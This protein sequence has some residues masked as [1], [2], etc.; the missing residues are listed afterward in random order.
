MPGA[1]GEHDRRSPDGRRDQPAK[2]PVSPMEEAIQAACGSLLAL[3]TGL[4]SISRVP[5][6]HAQSEAALT[7]AI[8]LVRE[9]IATLRQSTPRAARSPWS[10]GFVTTRG[11]AQKS[12]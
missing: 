9:A 3:Q 7:A 10:H 8:E 2:T 6:E 1:E 12:S 5:G 4:A 11:A